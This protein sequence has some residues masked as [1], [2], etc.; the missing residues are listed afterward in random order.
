VGRNVLFGRWTFQVVEEYD[1]GYF[2]V[3]KAFDEESLGLVGG[4]RHLYEASMK[5]DRRS[6][7]EPGHEA[8][9]AE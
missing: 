1:A 7:G 2:G 8:T 4:M 9:P 6:N 5:R 3:F